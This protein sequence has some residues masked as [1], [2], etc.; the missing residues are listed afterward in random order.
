MKR[1]LAGILGCAAITVA[2][3]ATASAATGSTDLLPHILPAAI[4]ALTSGSS[5]CALVPLP[6]PGGVIGAAD[7][8]PLAV[9]G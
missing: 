1:L 8:A 9:A 5:Q 2:V 7:P 3:P 4:C 6:A